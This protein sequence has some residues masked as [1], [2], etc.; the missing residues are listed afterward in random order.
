LLGRSH[1]LPDGGRVRLRLTQPR[2]L[3]HIRELLMA[4]GCA[5]V[6]LEVARLVRFDPR[7]RVVVCAWAWAD[8][9][10]QLVGVGAI[11]VGLEAPEL[12]CADEGRA[13]G[14]A[15]LLRHALQDRAQVISSRPAAA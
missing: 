5:A 2:D 8:G 3:R 11:E 10:E 14:L 6:D 9:S 1:R 13:P 15:E 7:R 12:V 4:R